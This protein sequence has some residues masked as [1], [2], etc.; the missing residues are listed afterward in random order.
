MAE[1]SG[2]GPRDTNADEFISRMLGQYLRQGEAGQGAA[3]VSEGKLTLQ[4]HIAV[5]KGL[6]QT[7]TS[8]TFSR[9]AT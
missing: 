9:L 4:A 3:A 5:D 8:R 7:P 1:Q 6:Y 2:S